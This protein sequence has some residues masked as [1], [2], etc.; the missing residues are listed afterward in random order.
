MSGASVKSES[1]QLSVD[2]S[3]SR[4]RWVATEEIRMVGVHG[5]DLGFILR[6]GES[7]LPFGQLGSQ[8]NSSTLFP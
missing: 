2:C 4:T 7:S 3:G 1:D 8:F 6:I 5:R